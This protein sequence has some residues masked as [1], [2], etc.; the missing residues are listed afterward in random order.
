MF[1]SC[2]N[3]DE[4]IMVIEKI[5]LQKWFSGE[6]FNYCVVIEPTPHLP[7]TYNEI[8]QRLRTISFNINKKYLGN[9][10][11]KFKNYRDRFFFVAF[12]EKQKTVN[13]YNIMVSIPSKIKRMGY[14]ISRNFKSEFIMEWCMLQSMNPYTWKLRKMDFENSNLNIEPIKN[15]KGSVFYNSKK[16]DFLNKVENDQSYFI[17]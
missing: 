8:T 16:M 15:I 6:E 11:S 17:C 7:F 14:Y 3:R 9:N 2:N 5:H 1:K 10:F 4:I 13:H 12:K